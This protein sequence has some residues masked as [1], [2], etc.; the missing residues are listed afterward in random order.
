M[1]GFCGGAAA[2]RASA[3]AEVGVLSPE[4]FLYYEDVDLSWRMRAAGRRVLHVPDAVVEHELAASSGTTSPVFRFHNDRNAL[5]TFTR[6]APAGVVWRAWLRFP[7]AVAWHAARPTTRPLVPVR[8]SALRA[9]VALLPRTLAERRA[10]W[11][12]PRRRREVATRWLD[13]DR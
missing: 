2:L 6:H 7:L 12:D 3:L 1:F 8:L 11:P 4:W 9:A 10:L 13:R 5:L